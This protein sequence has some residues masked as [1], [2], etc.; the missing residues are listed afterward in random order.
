MS[1]FARDSGAGTDTEPEVDKV[2]E[3]EP[4]LVDIGASSIAI[5]RRILSEERLRSIEP[6]V[7]S[8]LQPQ[9]RCHGEVDELVVTREADTGRVAEYEEEDEGTT[10]EWAAVGRVVTA[11]VVAAEEEENDEDGVEKCWCGRIGDGRSSFVP[12]YRNRASSYSCNSAHASDRNASTHGRV[13]YEAA[14][15]AVAEPTE[16]LGGGGGETCEPEAESIVEAKD[17]AEDKL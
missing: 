12:R 13:K 5:M 3:P 7:R 11:A 15:V 6:F 9:E 16:R 8:L 4:E 14:A 17:E 2:V 1:V 10:V